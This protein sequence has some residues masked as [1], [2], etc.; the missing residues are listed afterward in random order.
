MAQGLDR[1][2]LTGAQGR[3]P[4]GKQGNCGQYDWKTVENTKG[5]GWYPYRF[6]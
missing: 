2:D 6:A 4:E 1:I 5:S 3:Q